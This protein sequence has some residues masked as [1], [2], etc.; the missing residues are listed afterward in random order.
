M[1][2]FIKATIALMREVFITFLVVESLEVGIT[3][4]DSRSHRR[5]IAQAGVSFGDTIFFEDGA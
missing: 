3:P 1:S 4:N 5:D 2:L